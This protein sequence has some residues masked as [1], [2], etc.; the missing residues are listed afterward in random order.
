MSVLYTRHDGSTA[1]AHFPRL[2]ELYA[3]VYAEPPY[4][5]GPEQVSR[6]A[7]G[8]SDEARRPGFTL[9]SAEQNG[10]LIG[11]AYGLRMAAGRWWSS[12]DQ[13]PPA[14]ILG[15]DKLAVMEWMV[16]PGEQGRGVGAGLMTRL[17]AGRPEPWA[18][19]AADPRAPAREIYARAGW[20]QVARI[21][22]PWG[23][24]MDVLVRV[25][26]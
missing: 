11:A 4:E 1:T 26:G 14:H 22:A 18:T 3:R 8:L 13:D 19:L 6:F 24:S 16:V 7:A 20:Q 5:E 12:A 15:A 17:L 2:A 10:V 23:P 21:A 9:I 25:L